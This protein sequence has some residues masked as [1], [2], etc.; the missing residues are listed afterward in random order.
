MPFRLLPSF[1]S[2]KARVFCLRT[3]RTHPFISIDFEDSDCFSISL[4]RIH[5]GVS[6]LDNVDV[7]SSVSVDENN[8]VWDFGLVGFTG[9]VMVVDR[10]RNEKEDDSWIQ[11]LLSMTNNVV[12][13]G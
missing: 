4:I 5:F 11:R 6:A 7:S 3:V 12:I 8:L 13:I 10:V 1:T 9:F 2:T